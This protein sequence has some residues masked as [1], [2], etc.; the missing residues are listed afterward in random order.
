[1][2]TGA[3]GTGGR[4][5]AMLSVHVIPESQREMSRTKLGHGT[6][7]QQLFKHLP[8][9]VST[10]THTNMGTGDGDGNAEREWSKDDKG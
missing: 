6:V 7:R 4:W 10:Q 5:E 8:K 9:L 3:V 1:M 2:G